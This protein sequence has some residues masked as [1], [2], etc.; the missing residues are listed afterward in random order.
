MKKKNEWELKTQPNL[1]QKELNIRS[2]LS[3]FAGIM[4]AVTL[5][6]MTMAADQR[7]YILFL[8]FFAVLLTLYFSW[9][10]LNHKM[11]NRFKSKK[12]IIPVKSD[13][14]LT[15]FLNVI[16]NTQTPFGTPKLGLQDEGIFRLPTYILKDYGWVVYFYYKNQNIFS[17]KKRFKFENTIKND[18][19]NDKVVSLFQSD[20]VDYFCFVINEGRKPKKDEMDRLF[21]NL[22]KPDIQKNLV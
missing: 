6:L 17:K 3:I 22:P 2:F 16:M 15:G 14:N 8:V 19:A 18:V 12:K 21:K 7:K 11:Y 4:F 9:L 1:D 10:K 13:F 20:L 5:F